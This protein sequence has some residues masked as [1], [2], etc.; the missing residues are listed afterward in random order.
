MHLNS[1]QLKEEREKAELERSAQIE[2]AKPKKIAVK[3]PA[4][5]TFTSGVGKYINMAAQ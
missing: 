3:E 5:R 4:P 1:L 2:A